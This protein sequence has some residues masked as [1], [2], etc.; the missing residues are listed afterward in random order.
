M[1]PGGRLLLVLV[2]VAYAV[3]DDGAPARR[4]PRLVTAGAHGI[5]DLDQ[6]ARQPDAERYCHGYERL[7]RVG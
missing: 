5:Q 6:A 3:L 2:L 1:N 4:S 7:V